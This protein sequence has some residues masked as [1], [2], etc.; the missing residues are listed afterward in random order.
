VASPF[1]VRVLKAA[2]GSDLVFEAVGGAMLAVAGGFAVVLG[3]RYNARGR[4][5]L[6]AA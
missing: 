3:I 5:S 1:V 2:G 4:P 6:G